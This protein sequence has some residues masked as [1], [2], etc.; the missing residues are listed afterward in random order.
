MLPRFF[1][2]TKKYESESYR[3]CQNHVDSSQGELTRLYHQARENEARLVDDLD[4]A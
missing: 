3:F 1:G 2:G 4:I